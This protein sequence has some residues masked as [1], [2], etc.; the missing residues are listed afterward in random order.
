MGVCA[1]LWT[2]PCVTAERDEGCTSRGGLGGAPVV[3]TSP[4]L[5]QHASTICSAIAQPNQHANNTPS[6]ESTEQSTDEITAG[7]P[8][9][10]PHR[11]QAQGERKLGGSQPGDALSSPTLVEEVQEARMLCRTCCCLPRE[12]TRLFLSFNVTW[13]GREG[14]DKP[15]FVLCIKSLDAPTSSSSFQGFPASDSKS[16]CKSPLRCRPKR[17][18]EDLGF[19]PLLFGG[20]LK[21]GICLEKVEE[22]SPA[23]REEEI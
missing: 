18:R 4:P 6:V 5:S 11:C 10:C 1:H 13:G 7:F 12:R 15:C 19:K 3:T 16:S 23:H 14:K 21:K 17:R 2:S 22:A 20:K 9:A 8:E